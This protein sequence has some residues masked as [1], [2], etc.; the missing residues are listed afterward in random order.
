MSQHE[1]NHMKLECPVCS[2][3]YITDKLFAHVKACETRAEEMAKGC[4]D[5][6][7][8]FNLQTISSS[9]YELFKDHIENAHKTILCEICG[10]PYAGK[11]ELKDH[12]M[13]WN[14]GIRMALLWE[15][16]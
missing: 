10:T 5:C 13:F 4:P 2:R 12:M 9:G 16:F 7:K 14:L 15:T 3:K 11:E 6:D 1:R 8:V